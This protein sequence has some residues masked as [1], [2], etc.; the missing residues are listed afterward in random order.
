MLFVFTAEAVRMFDIGLDAVHVVGV[1]P[2][3][4]L[5]TSQKVCV[6]IS[7]VTQFYLLSSTCNC[8]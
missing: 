2:N 1:Q 6:D 7:L 4:R 8:V 3:S 5:R